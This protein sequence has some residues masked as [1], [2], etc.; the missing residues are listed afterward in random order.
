MSARALDFADPQTRRTYF[1]ELRQTLAD[2]YEITTE[3]VRRSGHGRLASRD[4]RERCRQA[5][6]RL[7]WLLSVAPPD[8]RV[9]LRG[10]A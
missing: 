8:V 1:A 2:V 9:L 5:R 6:D 3:A 10:A 7:E 4:D